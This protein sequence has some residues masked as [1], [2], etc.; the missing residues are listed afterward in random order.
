M[1]DD[2]GPAGIG[3]ALVTGLLIVATLGFGMASLCGAAFTVTALPEMFSSRRAENYA[4]AVLVVSV[5]TLVIAG[6]I[7]WWCLRSLR[8][9]TRGRQ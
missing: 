4:A 2:V 3:R 8:R 9:R 5:P 7:T 6:G 1:T